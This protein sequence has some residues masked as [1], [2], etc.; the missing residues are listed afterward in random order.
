[1]K[2]EAYLSAPLQTRRPT[3]ARGHVECGGKRSSLM[4]TQQNTARPSGSDYR[5]DHEGF[6][7][8]R[9]KVDGEP[10]QLRWIEVQQITYVQRDI[11]VGIPR[12]ALRF[13]NDGGDD[14]KFVD[15]DDAGFAALISVICAVPGI[16]P[17]AFLGTP[18]TGD[19]VR[20]LW[21]P[22]EGERRAIGG[23]P[24]VAAF[25]SSEGFRSVIDRCAALD[26]V[27]AARVAADAKR[28]RRRRI[29]LFTG[30]LIAL[31]AMVVWRKLMKRQ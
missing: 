2:Q 25:F 31:A 26:G 15:E 14:A 30:T 17:D 7:V 22:D 21:P 29:L 5:L 27:M 8:A 20:R 4:S 24:A 19:V 13:E 23:D 1:M 9:S 12:S 18:V 28:N 10:L 6:Y 3:A 11:G 16:A